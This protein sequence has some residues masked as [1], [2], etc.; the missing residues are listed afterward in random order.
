MWRYLVLLLLLLNNAF[1]ERLVLLTSLPSKHQF[2]E[3]KLERIF[4]KKLAGHELVIFHQANQEQLYNELN[5]PTNQAVFW[6]SHGSFVKTSR[7]AKPGALA[8]TP[9]LLTHDMINVAPLYEKVAMEINFLGIIGC[10]SNSIIK[11]HL[12]QREFLSVYAPTRKVDA[13]LALRKAIRKFQKSPKYQVT[14]TEVSSEHITITRSEMDPTLSYRSLQVFMGG[15]FIGLLPSSINSS[16]QIQ[17]LSIQNIER[18]R[19]GLKISLKTGEVNTVESRDFA[20]L[21]ISYQDG[22]YWKLFAR[23][24]GQPFGATERLFLPL[25]TNPLLESL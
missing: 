15:K 14:S 8:T 17:S 4:K 7:R 11:D 6:L 22:D 16:T 24:N 21:S 10:N 5:N 2:L 1:A 18:T 9:Y 20:S 19:R 3:P 23:S 13:R 12:S 25:P